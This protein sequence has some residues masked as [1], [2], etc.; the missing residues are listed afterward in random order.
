MSSILCILNWFALF[1]SI[2]NSQACLAK[3]TQG[4]T[5]KTETETNMVSDIKTESSRGNEPS[6]DHLEKASETLSLSKK[7]LGKNVSVVFLH[8]STGGI[9]IYEGGINEWIDSYNKTHKTNYRMTDIEYPDPNSF[10]NMP[11]DYWNIW[12]DHE[13]SKPYKNQPTLELLTKKYS[14]IIWKHCFP[15]S[16]I[17]ADKGSPDTK[18]ST[19]SIANYKLQYNAL[20]AKMR[21]FSKN[22]FILW[23]GAALIQ[24]ETDENQATRA[25]KFFNWVKNQ[26][27]E[28]GDNIFIW[29][30]RQLE[31]EGGL[32]LIAKNSNGQDSHPGGRFAKSVTP[33]FGKRIVEVIQGRGDSGSLTGQ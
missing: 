30:F 21:Q 13:G 15:V 33:L 3:G 9:L 22:R 18:S 26:W 8:H 27:D 32:Y 7:S 4:R 29:D 10:G 20:K 28:P 5:G 24:K 1:L 11:Y 17:V 14:V 23:T 16:S 2:T 25:K 6:A 12:V 19:Q 31:T